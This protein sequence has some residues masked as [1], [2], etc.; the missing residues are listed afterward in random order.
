MQTL[1]RLSKLVGVASSAASAVTDAVRRGEQLRFTVSAGA[2][3]YLHAEHADVSV[4]RTAA[5]SAN[6]P[7]T[8]TIDAR[9]QPPFAWRLVTEQ[10]DA[11][12][13]IVAMRHRVAK[14]MGSVTGG[15]TTMR[16]DVSAPLGVAILLRLEGARVTL[17]NMSGVIELPPNG[18]VPIIR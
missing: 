16:L 2:A 13:Y 9:W 6:A 5:T 12:I 1:D 10:D 17:D 14:W 15:L 18:N 4:T 11:G 3:L 8:I 7:L